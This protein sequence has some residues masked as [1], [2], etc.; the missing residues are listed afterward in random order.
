MQHASLFPEFA[1]DA[2]PETVAP[3]VNAPHVE[4]PKAQPLALDLFPEVGLFADEDEEPAEA[5]ADAEE[6]SPIAE[7]LLAAV[8]ECAPVGTPEELIDALATQIAKD[9]A[10]DRAHIAE[11]FRP[12]RHISRSKPATERPH[13]DNS[14][15]SVV[16]AVRQHL[17]GKGIR[18]AVT[19]AASSGADQHGNASG[20]R[21]SVAHHLG[22]GG[23]TQDEILAA[24]ADFPGFTPQADTDQCLCGHARHVH[25]KNGKGCADCYC[26]WLVG[27]TMRAEFWIIFD[28][29][30][31]AGDR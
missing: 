12:G 11:A 3:R 13:M 1:G 9:D 8:V 26:R 7:A 25:T 19:D 15:S 14:R 27:V 29:P 22:K 17:R 10:A 4:G 24:L 18:K 5:L 6:V 28:L 20:W 21:V 31:V 2:A 30:V 23:S 16:K